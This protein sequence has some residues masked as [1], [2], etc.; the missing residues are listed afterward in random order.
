MSNRLFEKKS[1]IQIIPYKFPSK[2]QRKFLLSF[3]IFR[4]EG[5]YRNFDKYFFSLKKLLKE[6]NISDCDVCI[7]VDNSVLRY[8]PFRDWIDND[9]VKMKHVYVLQYYC[10]DFIKPGSDY[11]YG[12]FGSIMRLYA[13]TDEF[14]TTSNFYPG[15]PYKKYDAVFISDVDMQPFEVDQKAIY[16]MIENK[17]S[18][19]Y[20]TRIYYNKV[21]A[22]KTLEF[23]IMIGTFI[24][25]VYYPIDLLTMYLKNLKY[26]K[27]NND[28]RAII[29]EDISKQRR[30][31]YLTNDPF[32][33]GMD[34]YFAN[35]ILIQY[36]RKLYKKALVYVDPFVN[37]LPYL[38][39][40]FK[41]SN[42]I[43][44]SNVIDIINSFEKLDNPF[45][46]KQLIQYYQE[47]Y[48]HLVKTNF[49]DPDSRSVKEYVLRAIP[50]M[51]DVDFE[52]LQTTILLPI[53]AYDKTEEYEKS[54]DD[55]SKEY[56]QADSALF[57]GKQSSEFEELSKCPLIT[58][59]ATNADE[60]K[61]ITTYPKVSLSE[62]AKKI[63][64]LTEFIFKVRNVKQP[65]YNESCLDSK[66]VGEIKEWSNM[67][68]DKSDKTLAIFDVYGVV[69]NTVYIFAPQ[70][71]HLKH[72]L[73][74][75]ISE[76]IS[77]TKLNISF[78]ELLETYIDFYKNNGGTEPISSFNSIKPI[79]MLEYYCYGSENVSMI[80]QMFNTLVKNK[81]KILF[82]SGNKSV[83]SAPKFYNEL[84]EH[85]LQPSEYELL[86]IGKD[87]SY[88]KYKK[89]MDLQYE[90]LC[91]NEMKSLYSYILPSSR[92]KTIKHKILSNSKTR[93]QM[94]L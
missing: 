6:S 48:D 79:H 43:S 32:V 25:S 19:C 92:S 70:F 82:M 80:K 68:K 65:Y 46:K 57:V 55:K 63:K 35:R 42:K 69:L 15:K 41:T 81:T 54:I 60:S 78:D 73:W 86:L 20:R 76:K 36:Y 11:H 84:L 3:A 72:A 26:K 29:E 31:I 18:V 47:L 8:K 56:K 5:A 62:N 88:S 75:S 83:H 45:Y 37:K 58:T 24:S 17:A 93:K 67:N 40:H 49:E 4:M 33:Y 10:K 74:E 16:H 30:H 61:L 77:R 39:P 91:E 7:F 23:P 44:S 90:N 28:V 53:S 64:L 22:Q 89:L 51:K 94:K 13:L 34:E 21:W 52:N 12:P 66:I 2:E 27:F 71:E 59:I 1:T 38:L 50:F 87:V 85:F 9:V 14:T